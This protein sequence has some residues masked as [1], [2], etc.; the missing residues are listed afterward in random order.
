MKRIVT[1]ILAT[2][3]FIASSMAQELMVREFRPDAS[4]L[5][6]VVHQVADANGNP[7]ALVRLGLAVPD[8]SFE[9]DIIKADPKDGEYWIY[10]PEG[11]NW[12]NVKTSQY[13]PLRYDFPEAVKANTTYVLNAMPKPQE[14]KG[15]GDVVPVTLPARAA[16]SIGGM[17]ADQGQP[18]TF[19][20]IKV[21][22]GMY[23]MGATPE[24]ESHEGDEQPVHWVTISKDFYI[25]ETEV[26]QELWE[27]VMN[28]N[29]SV[30]KDPQLPVTNVSWNDAKEFIRALNQ[31]T[32][33]RFR[34]PTEAEWEYAARGGHQTG[35]FKYSGSNT[36][37]EVG[38]WYIN[39][40][41]RP[42]PVK[43]LKPNELGIYDMSGNVWELC[44]DYKN[45]Y[46]KKDV[47]DQFGASP[48][49]NR[50]RRGGGWD[51]ENVDQ[52]RN[53]YRRRVEEN[54]RERSTGFRLVLTTD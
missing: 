7:C 51:S 31:I 52:L 28:S 9:G 25:G 48:G 37:E 22:S 46:P 33:V 26:T 23:K 17:A 13:V 20:M 42:N 27:Y 29:P 10:M 16:A 18:V 2:I 36:A 54:M 30:I 39:S 47:V 11:S 45:D 3:F 19:N 50:V 43:S 14:K 40:S 41:S 6:A 44:E 24:Q 34:L 5:S 49:K 1:T 12:L 8:A 15:L 38:Y 21:K 4:D 35:H 32:R 53:A